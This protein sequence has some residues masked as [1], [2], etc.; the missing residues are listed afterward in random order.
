MF[1]IS[2]PFNFE[3]ALADNLRL[4][5]RVRRSVEKVWTSGKW[6]GCLKTQMWGSN[7]SRACLVCAE[8]TDIANLNHGRSDNDARLTCQGLSNFFVNNNVHFDSSLGSSIQHAVDAVL[9]VGRWRP[10]QIEFRAQPPFDGSAGKWQMVVN[11]PTIQ[12]PYALL[13]LLQCLGYSPHVRT[14]INVPLDVV[15]S[16]GRSEAVITMRAVVEAVCTRARSMR[17][18]MY[19]N[20]RGESLLYI[21]TDIVHT[22]MHLVEKG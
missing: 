21:G 1:F 13:C 3:A 6:S 16:S 14:A 22:S 17:V 15:A 20:V 2:V 8:E 12:D 19:V 18:C 7:A 4:D 10:T 11:G 9:F 5:R